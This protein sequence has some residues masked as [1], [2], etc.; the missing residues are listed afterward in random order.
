MEVGGAD[1]WLKKCNYDKIYNSV[2]NRQI[3]ILNLYIKQMENG[4]KSGLMKKEYDCIYK[5]L[6]S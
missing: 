6:I 1:D 4:G 3:L 5:I 2:Y